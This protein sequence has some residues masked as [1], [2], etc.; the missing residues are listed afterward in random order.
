MGSHRRPKPPS[1]SRLAVLA[2]TAGTVS[3]LPTQ[4]QAAPKP[5]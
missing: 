1:R 5:S 2:A 4:S 3:L